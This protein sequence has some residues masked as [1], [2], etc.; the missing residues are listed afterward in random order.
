MD[1]LVLDVDGVLN[2]NLDHNTAKNEELIFF[3]MYAF[4]SKAKL[5]LLCETFKG[6]YVI[7]SSDWRRRPLTMLGISRL[8]TENG[9]H[10]LSSTDTNGPHRSDEIR[11][12]LTFFN[13]RSAIILDDLGAN[14]VDPHM[15]NA[16]FHQ[17][18][19]QVGFT[20]EDADKI[21]SLIRQ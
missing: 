17:V 16:I 12:A 18:D 6:F 8:L 13:Y 7:L 5:K 19:F 3:G 2:S 4:I 10:F 9:L 15:P 11:R 21:N 14:E 20:E 1:V